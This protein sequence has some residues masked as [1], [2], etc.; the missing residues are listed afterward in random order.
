MGTLMICI[1]YFYN[2]AI[3]PCVFASPSIYHI[4]IAK[5]SI[6]TLFVASPSIFYVKTTI[7][8]P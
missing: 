5:T 6:K 4:D 7:V 8:K 1:M 2:G 3:K